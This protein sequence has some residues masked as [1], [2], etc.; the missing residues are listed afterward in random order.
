MM[1]KKADDRPAY[2]TIIAACTRIAVRG[3]E[4]PGGTPSGIRAVGKA[5]TQPPSRP[6]EQV[7][8]LPMPQRT[9]GQQL[10]QDINRLGMSGSSLPGISGSRVNPGVVIFALVAVAVFAVGLVMYLRRD[11]AQAGTV[12]ISVD[13]APWVLPDAAPSGPAVPEGMLLVASGDLEKPFWVGRVAVTNAE[14]AAWK[15]S[16]TFAPKDADRPVTGV[17]YDYAVAYARS[18]GGRL[19][20]AEE[21]DSAIMTPQFTPP[22]MKLWEWVDEGDGDRKVRA[23][24]GVNQRDEFRKAAG[25]A[26]VTFRLAI[27][28]AP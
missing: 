22:G 28:T 8:P 19:V 27:D 6:T 20:R 7:A 4:M 17:A 3:G 15:L 18:K 2:E 12:P 13:A 5:A 24:R 14:F 9:S 16:H 1:A 25:D 10:E 11:T 26:S 23:V 21:W